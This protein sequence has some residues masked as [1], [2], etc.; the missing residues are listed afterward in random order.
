MTVRKLMGIFILESS[1]CQRCGG[2]A[3]LG[4]VVKPKSIILLQGEVNSSGSLGD[5]KGLF[6]HQLSL[7][8]CDTGEFSFLLQI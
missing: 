6:H 5:M 7:R 2:P 1:V 4:A 8:S 3:H